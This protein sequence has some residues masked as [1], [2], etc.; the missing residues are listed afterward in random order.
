MTK[1]RYTVIAVG[2]VASAAFIFMA[3]RGLD[4]DTLRKVWSDAR[5]LP[6]LPLGIASYLLGHVVR[7]VRCRL[8]VRREATIGL[9]TAS[10][11][12][13]V[14]YASNNVLPARLGEFV[15]AGMLAERTGMPI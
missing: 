8:L 9:P 6:W 4:F 3:V 12:V 14:G 15:R 7:G 1:Q 11:I 5:V 10:N 13:V 2:L